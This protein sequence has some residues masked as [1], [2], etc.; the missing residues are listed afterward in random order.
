MNIKSILLNLALLGSLQFLS[1]ANAAEPGEGIAFDPLTGN[2]TVSYFVELDDGRKLLQKTHFEPATKIDPLVKS[3]LSLDRGNAVLYRYSI[4]SGPRSQQVLG[5][6]RLNLTASILG[7]QELPTTITPATELQIATIL[8]ANRKALTVPLGWNGSTH[9]EQPGIVRVS[10]NAMGGTGIQSGNSLTGFGF[11]SL[12]IPDIGTVELAGVRKRRITYAGDGPQGD[13]AQQFDALR[14]KDFVSRYVTV[15]AIAVPVPY[16]AAALLDG[17]RSHVAAWPGKQLLDPAFAAQ[18]D[19]GMVAAANA[20]RNNQPKAGK[21]HIEALRKLL[22]HE[23]KYLDHDDEDS[24]DTREHKT[25]TRLTIDRVAAR[26]L[27][28]DLRYV[29]KRMEKAHEHD[30]DKGD[31]RNAR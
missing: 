8:D 6:V 19:R 2:Y 14:Q 12:D 3:R 27:D 29:L 16:D 11:Y 30:H 25:A 5:T 1:I 7:V 24:E 20:Y 13:I 23:H 26:V 28:F 17:I 10:W 22:E 4:S 18:L 9:S 21:E 31:Q 15:P